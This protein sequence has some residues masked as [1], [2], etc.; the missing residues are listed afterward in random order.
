MVILMFI[1]R[2]SKVVNEQSVTVSNLLNSLRYLCQPGPAQRKGQISTW[3]LYFTMSLNY[4]K[5]FTWMLFVLI[6]SIH[7]SKHSMD[8]AAY[9]TVRMRRTTS[10]KR[11]LTDT[12]PPPSQRSW[13]FVILNLWC[14]WFCWVTPFTISWTGWLSAW[15]L[16]MTLRA[17]SAPPLQ[18]FVTSYPMNWVS[19][20]LASF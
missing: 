10:P 14:G 2:R 20:N 1:L 6:L 9:M 15:R 7:S 4:F 18:S 19:F 12:R 13:A 16:Q 11:E 17:E 3:K 8:R 5:G